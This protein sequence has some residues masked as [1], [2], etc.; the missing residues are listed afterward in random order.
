MRWPGEWVA[1]PLSEAQ[2]VGSWRENTPVSWSL[3]GGVS[4]TCA[5][6]KGGI[7]GRPQRRLESYA[8]PGVRRSKPETPRAGRRETDAP[9]VSTKLVWAFTHLST[10]PWERLISRR[11]APPSHELIWGAQ[12][13]C[14]QWLLREPGPD[15]IFAPA[16]TRACAWMAGEMP[17][18]RH[19]RT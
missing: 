7:D 17:L 16:E 14:G 15:R 8:S 10:P 13:C 5:N 19:A 12:R 4:G 9:A 3:L 1:T 18:R 6:R 2:G 11:P